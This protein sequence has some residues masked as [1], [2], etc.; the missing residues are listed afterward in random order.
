MKTNT[1]WTPCCAIPFVTWRQSTVPTVHINQLPTNS[2]HSAHR[3]VLFGCEGQQ[4]I[5]RH[6]NDSVEGFGLGPL[7]QLGDCAVCPHAELFRDAKE[8]GGVLNGRQ[9]PVCVDMLKWRL[10]DVWVMSRPLAVLRA[11]FCNPQHKN[12]MCKL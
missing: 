12:N 11:D 7:Q 4:V 8:A 3:W 2:T 5:V 6:N 1:V 9:G 10:V